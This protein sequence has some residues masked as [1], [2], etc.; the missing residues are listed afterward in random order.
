MTPH[1]P[2]QPPTGTALAPTAPGQ[3]VG[4]VPARRGLH[5]IEA[6][7]PYLPD[8][9]PALYLFGKTV[10][11][12]DWQLAAVRLLRELGWTG[13]VL[14][15]R[16]SLNPTGSPYD[17]WRPFGWQER[18]VPKCSAVLFWNAI[19]ADRILSVYTAGLLAEPGTV[20]V[21]GS[22]PADTLPATV[23]AALAALADRAARR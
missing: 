12:P 18:N 20:V 5:Y 10:D 4:P 15:P 13:T 6:P 21:V 16:P 17:A 14:N 11:C 3:S 7:A 1:H 23:H 22:D 9:S 19:T 8:G 2:N